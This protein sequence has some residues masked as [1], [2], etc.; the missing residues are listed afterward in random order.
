MNNFYNN[1]LNE[2]R[3]IQSGVDKKGS[4]KRLG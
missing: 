4:I 2:K 1:R 3:L